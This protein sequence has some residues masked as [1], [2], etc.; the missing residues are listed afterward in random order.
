MLVVGYTIYE[1]MIRF[2]H[3]ILILKHLG[4]VLIECNSDGAPFKS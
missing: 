3:F 2:V 1:H 4:D